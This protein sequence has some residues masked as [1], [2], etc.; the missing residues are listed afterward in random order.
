MGLEIGIYNIWV[1]MGQFLI[2]LRVVV[3]PVVV[4]LESTNDA[5]H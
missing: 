1:K 2:C 4:R 3:T 5:C